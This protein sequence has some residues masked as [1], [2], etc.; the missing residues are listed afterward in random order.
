MVSRTRTVT[1]KEY[2]KDGKLIKETIEEFSEDSYPD[3]N[4][5]TPAGGGNWW[6]KTGDN[7]WQ[8]PSITWNSTMEMRN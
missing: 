6:E 5:T 3:Y 8:Q 2:D 7:W 1:T 4:G